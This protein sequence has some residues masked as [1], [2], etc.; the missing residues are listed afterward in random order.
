MKYTSLFLAIALAL[1]ACNNNTNSQTTSPQ[2]EAATASTAASAPAPAAHNPNWETLL[3]GS[4][5][6][7][8]PFE[9]KDN[10][11]QPI[12]FEVDLLNAIAH[13][14]QM[15]LQFVHNPRNQM[16][17]T[18]N[19]G[20]FSIFASAISVTPERSAQVD[21]TQPYMDFQRSIMILDTPENQNIKTIADLNGKKIATNKSSQSNIKLITQI[22][23]SPN[24]VVTTDTFYLSMKEVYAGNAV[25][26]IG[27][28]STLAYYTKQNA[29]VQTRTLQT[30]EPVRQLAF[31]VKKG[32]TELL[33]KLNSGLE[34]I[35]KDGTYDKIYDKWFKK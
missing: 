30:D 6:N 14:E 17:D 4:E 25:G 12:G 2:P 33:N 13:A 8:T 23:G 29:N 26:V 3:V 28:D 32:N 20:K 15:N 10:N 21:F 35:K 9:F 7:Y 16:V 18:L 19:S 11:G 24:N 31:A 5:I 22:S 27:D 34:K 1:T